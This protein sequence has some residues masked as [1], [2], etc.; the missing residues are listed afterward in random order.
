MSSDW[1]IGDN[2][3]RSVYGLYDFGDFDSTG[4]MGNP[5]VQLL[6]IVD[7]NNASAAFTALRGG[8][9]RNNIT[10]N[11][12]PSSGSSGSTSLS[13]SNSVADKLGKLVDFIP[14]ILSV[15]ALNALALF[16]ISIVVVV[17]MCRRGRGS[18][19]SQKKGRAGLAL[20]GRT[21]TPYPMSPTERTRAGIPDATVD[22]Q[23]YERISVLV[24][25]EPEDQPFTPPEPSFQGYDG[26][27]LGP[28]NSSFGSGTRPRSMWS[29]ASGS[30][31][32]PILRDYRMSTA[33]SDMTVFVP[34]SPKFMKDASSDRP[35][36][37][38]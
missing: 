35:K 2:V 33:G 4:A 38:A 22:A 3:L 23:G 31:G 9:P 10:Y 29:T 24:P 19:K 30:S 28:L 36:S 6:P 25:G 26:D 15:L 11:A 8:T 32:R 18:N 12:T 34:P 14:A 37:V 13:V 16:V 17:F 27:S 20:S 1:L 7:P 21:P 5:Y